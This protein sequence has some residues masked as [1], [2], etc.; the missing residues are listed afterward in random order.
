MIAHAQR[1][2]VLDR[3]R[4]YGHIRIGLN[5]KRVRGVTDGNAISVSAVS[6]IR[7]YL[8]GPVRGIVIIG[9]ANVADVYLASFASVAEQ[10]KRCRQRQPKSRAACSS[11]GATH[12]IFLLHPQTNVT[13]L[14]RPVLVE[15][16]GF[17]PLASS[18]RTTRSTN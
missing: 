17:E 7:H 14:L 3:Q 6:V 11:W 12:T 2:E 18:L 8:R 4:V 13:L 1:T 10:G 16:R 5:A 9:A 15:V